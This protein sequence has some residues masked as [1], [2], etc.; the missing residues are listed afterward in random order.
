MIRIAFTVL[1]MMA[2]QAAAA[3]GAPANFVEWRTGLHSAAQPSADWLATVKDKGYDLV[4]NLAPPQSHG[5]LREEGGI[6]GAK[7]VTYVNIPVNFGNPTAEDFRMFTEV[8]KAAAR[9][10]VFVHCQVNMRGSAF[11]F[12]YRVLHE[13]AEIGET[14]RKLNGVWAPDNVWKRFIDDTLAAHG[15]KGEVY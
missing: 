2:A 10:S 4:V 6:V 11:V 12:L 5:S 1:L 3:Q 15:R 13:G 14:G 8:M 9:K 7:G